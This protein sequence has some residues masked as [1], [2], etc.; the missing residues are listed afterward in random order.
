[1]TPEAEIPSSDQ[2]P[3][4]RI[5]GRVAR[6]T[7]NIDQSQLEIQL[8]CT[9][10]CEH[11][12]FAALEH[13]KLQ[14]PITVFIE[15]IHQILGQKD[16]QDQ[17]T[18]IEALHT[19]CMVLMLQL[20]EMENG[21]E[22]TDAV[23][24]AIQQL[25]NDAKQLFSSIIPRELLQKDL[26][27]C[28]SIVNDFMTSFGSLSSTMMARSRVANVLSPEQ[29]H[30]QN[31]QRKN[32]TFSD[33]DNVEELLKF[34]IELGFL[35]KEKTSVMSSIR[36]DPEYS[37]RPNIAVDGVLKK[38]NF[39]GNHLW[40]VIKAAFRQTKEMYDTVDDIAITHSRVTR[41]GS[42]VRFCKGID[43]NRGIVGVKLCLSKNPE[44]S[45]SLRNEIHMLK[46]LQKLGTHPHIVRLIKDGVMNDYPYAVVEYLDGG[47]LK[48]VLDKDEPLPLRSLLCI[49]ASV[50]N[51]LA[52][53]ETLGIHYRDT[54]MTNIMF[55]KDG[56]VKL[57]DFGLSGKKNPAA[58]LA[59][60]GTPDY[61]PPEIIDTSNGGFYK[62]D[63]KSDIWSVAAVIYDMVSG[64][65]P[66]VRIAIENSLEPA[67]KN[68]E[69]FTRA[70]KIFR[71]HEQ[72]PVPWHHAFER[73][74]DTHRECI[75]ELI[76]F[77][78]DISQINWQNRP[79]AFVALMK[80]S[81]IASR[82][83][84]GLMP[85]VEMG[86][87]HPYFDIEKPQEIRN[88][89]LLDFLK[90]IAI[91]IPEDELALLLE[92]ARSNGS[93]KKDT[94]VRHKTSSP[95]SAAQST[96]VIEGLD[97]TPRNTPAENS[98]TESA[99]DMTSDALP[100]AIPVPATLP[101]T[102]SVDDLE[103]VADDV[104]SPPPVGHPTL[105]QVVDNQIV[106]PALARL[107]ESTL[108]NA[109]ASSSDI[110]IL[111]PDQNPPSHS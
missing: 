55:T 64:E 80:I 41:Q 89:A 83:F 105:A 24:T 34:C 69:K 43:T 99:A 95:L 71:L 6:I 59:I 56:T 58:D 63:G 36:R 54:N 12:N 72:Y 61:A 92:K 32:F 90:G 52:Y 38:S 50:F 86:S 22:A 26:P 60:K 28:Q 103:I 84:P 68:E 108:S 93:S 48:D 29:S 5:S 1:M 74:D 18:H 104:T 20:F 75:D 81:E 46:E 57:M 44:H 21:L 42:F 10:F 76:K 19:Q 98:V 102:S 110:D 25:F 4:N 79:T 97:F 27:Q 16:T 100:R 11:L 23:H 62:L 37:S 88:K 82:H 35:V 94:T 78:S 14:P 51:A 109:N 45:E 2:Q 47:T 107:V 30:A 85:R 73:Y 9:A 31:P 39:L 33:P 91:R 49:T 66:H 17:R 40:N 111:P 96:D 106:N 53:M 70:M 77:F 13:P 15:S 65:P 7:L 67:G 101:P 3:S 87:D 8:R